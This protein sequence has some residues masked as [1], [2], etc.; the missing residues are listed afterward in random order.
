MFE[1]ELQS[2][3][4]SFGNQHVLKDIDLTIKKGECVVLLGSSGAGKSTLLNLMNGSLT[5]DS[6]AVITGGCNLKT[7]SARERLKSQQT[8]S[9]IYQQFNL[10]NN[11]KVI[12]NVNAGHLARWSF[13]KALLSLFFPRERNQALAVLKRVGIANKINHRTDLLSGGEQQRVA[14]ARMLIQDPEIILADEP[15]ASLDPSRRSEVMEIF[16]SL[17]TEE[18]K[19]IIMSLHD[20][21]FAGLH[22]PRAIGLRDGKIEFDCPYNEVSK[23]QLASLYR[24]V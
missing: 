6:G 14:L 17:C 1:Y 20:L 24:I 8:I 13:S 9:T 10:V 5:P 15:L 23:D 7:A 4:K 21:E 19:T 18:G 22:N 3:S 16:H 11:L 12:H 2:V